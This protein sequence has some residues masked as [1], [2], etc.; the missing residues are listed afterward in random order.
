MKNPYYIDETCVISLSGGRTSAYMLIEMLEAHGG[1]LPPEHHVLFANTGKEVD[2]TLDFVHRIERELSVPVVWLEYSGKKQFKIVDYETAARNGEPFRQ[3]IDDR[4]YLP[5]SMVRICTIEM[6]IL[7]IERYMESIGFD[8]FA[9]AV[10]IRAD[11][12][13]RVAKMKAK[14]DYYTPLADA[15]VTVQDIKKFWDGM[16]W[17]LETSSSHYSNCDLCMLKGHGIKMSLI[18]DGVDPSWWIEQE[19]RTGNFFRNDQPSYQAMADYDGQQID[20]FSDESISC[21]CGD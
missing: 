20:I 18:R 1:T 19:K 15:G 3:L 2:A 12:P 16:P 14:P 10:G 5:N 17:D 11:E 9:T 13:R 21:F 8:E 6:K 4:K 7:T